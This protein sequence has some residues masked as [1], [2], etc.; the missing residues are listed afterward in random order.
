MYKHIYHQ[1]MFYKDY[2]K[3]VLQGERYE[4]ET[5]TWTHEDIHK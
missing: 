4:I 5:W 3:E 1:Y 2:Q